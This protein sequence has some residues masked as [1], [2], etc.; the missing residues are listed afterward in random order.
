M[1]AR[2]S[3]SRRR[4]YRN[5][6]AVRVCDLPGIGGGIVGRKLPQY[7]IGVWRLLALAVARCDRLAVVVLQHDAFLLKSDREAST[8]GPLE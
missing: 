6:A 1:S 2:R 8:V 5:G 4:L 7:R 3:A